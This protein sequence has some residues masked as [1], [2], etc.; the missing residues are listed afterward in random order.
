VPTLATSASARSVS[1]S[2]SGGDRVAPKLEREVAG[3]DEATEFVSPDHL[4]GASLMAGGAIP[5]VTSGA[6]GML[7]LEDRDAPKP[8]PRLDAVVDLALAAEASGRP[9][10]AIQ[11]L[12]RGLRV[13]RTSTLLHQLARLYSVHLEDHARAKDHLDEARR[14]E[15]C[16]PNHEVALSFVATRHGSTLAKT[17]QRPTI[18]ASIATWAGEL[19]STVRRWLNEWVQL[20]SQ[21]RPR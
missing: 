14:L 12:E 19:R 8:P 21:R 6:D 18:R 9:H 3:E 2:A 16:N 7:L 15:P 1:P 20:W 5:L 13:E 11:I 4:A 10:D 17:S